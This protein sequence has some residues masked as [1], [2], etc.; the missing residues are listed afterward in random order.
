M[1]LT[2]IKSDSLPAAGPGILPA[3][4]SDLNVFNKF[5][6]GRAVTPELVKEFFTHRAELKPATLNRN[7]AAIKA[8]IITGSGGANLTALQRAEIDSFFKTIKPGAAAGA[9]LENKYLTIQELQ[10][11]IKKA[12]PK[13][14]LFIRALYETAARNAELLSVKITDCIINHNQVT[15][16]IRQGKGNKERTVYMSLET[17]QQARQLYPDSDYLFPV[18]RDT[19]NKLLMKAGKRILKRKLTPHMMRHTW[20]TLNI[21]AKILTISQI[22]KYL[23]HANPSTTAKFYL[24]GQ[25]K[26][27]QIQAVNLIILNKAA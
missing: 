5:A 18:H 25:A 2:H 7:K 24:H 9:I 11:I 12:G 23:G 20:A 3:Y 6:Q 1:N 17:Y 16:N 14:A 19:V 21:E 15:V 10:L 13:T 8:A 4:K 26:A 27:E 22:S